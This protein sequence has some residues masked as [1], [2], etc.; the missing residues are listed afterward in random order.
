[1]VILTCACAAENEDSASVQ[2]RVPIYAAAR[3]YIG[4]LPRAIRDAAVAQSGAQREGGGTHRIALVIVRHERRVVH[5]DNRV[6]GVVDVRELRLGGVCL[7]HPVDI[8][9]VPDASFLFLGVS[10]KFE[11]GDAPF[12]KLS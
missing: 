12:V 3:R 10:A 8:T 7:G 6:P 2:E 5:L 9:Y 1:M 11:R 4:C